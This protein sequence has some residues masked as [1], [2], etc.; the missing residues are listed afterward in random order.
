[1]DALGQPIDGL[2]AVKAKE[3]ANVETRAPGIIE[4]RSVHEPV[5]TGLKIIDSL[6][7]RRP[8]NGKNVDNC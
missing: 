2:G 3:F 6:I 7:H 4:R 1:M 8:P 5:Q